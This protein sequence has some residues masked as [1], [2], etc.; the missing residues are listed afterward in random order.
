MNEFRGNRSLQI[1]I[2]DIWPL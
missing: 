1:I 2:D